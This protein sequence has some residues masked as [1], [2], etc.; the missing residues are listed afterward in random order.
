MGQLDTDHDCL[1]RH[2]D[3][4]M[5]IQ[6]T[7]VGAGFVLYTKY[8]KPEITAMKAPNWARAL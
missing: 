7:K 1:I 3:S 6:L 8:E 4:S 5:N 2:A